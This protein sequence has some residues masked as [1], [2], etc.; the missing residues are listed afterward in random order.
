[1]GDVNQ[2][3]GRRRRASEMF[4]LLDA[5][6]PQGTLKLFQIWLNLPDQRQA[7]GTYFHDVLPTRATTSR[8]FTMP[9]KA[10][11]VTLTANSTISSRAPPN[12]WAARE[13]TDVAIWSIALRGRSLMDRAGGAG[14]PHCA[15]PLSS[16]G[17]R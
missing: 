14:R 3:G 11:P 10:P 6:E 16:P 7:G 8:R 15:N 12:S 4:P 1:M 2:R 13:Q 5:R 9:R 17:P